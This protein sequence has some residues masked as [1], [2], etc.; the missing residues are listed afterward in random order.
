M[1]YAGSV[2]RRGV[3]IIERVEKKMRVHLRLQEIQ[4][5]L[6]VL[7]DQLDW[8]SG[9]GTFHRA[10]KNEADQDG[11]GTKIN[12]IHHIIPKRGFG[13]VIPVAE[14]CGENDLFEQVA[15]QDE[16]GEQ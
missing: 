11:N 1:R 3:D 5:R 15:E 14:R 13:I 9:C 12:I 2:R 16:P 10:G 4:F 7:P 6:F 8:R